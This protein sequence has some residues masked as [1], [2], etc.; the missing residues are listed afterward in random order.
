MEPK[1]RQPYLLGLMISLRM[2]YGAQGFIRRLTSRL[3]RPM[4]LELL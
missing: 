2:H 1:L 3:K 4:V